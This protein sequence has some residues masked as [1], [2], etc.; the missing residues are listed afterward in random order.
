MP[1]EAVP[2]ALR[3]KVRSRLARILLTYIVADVPGGDGDEAYVPCL[4][5]L[6]A[7]S[8]IGLCTAEEA[9]SELH[10]MYE[11]G[12]LTYLAI[13]PDG[14]VVADPALPEVVAINPGRGRT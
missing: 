5:S 12:L 14:G 2:Y 11:L 8:E 7:L 9:R 4:T 6:S 13:D 10:S 1:T 3:T